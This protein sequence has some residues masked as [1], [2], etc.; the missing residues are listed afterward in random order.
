MKTLFQLFTGLS[1]LLLSNLSLSAQLQ[2]PYIL[3][4]SATQQS[5]NC[6]VLTEDVMNASGTAWNKNKISLNN[7]FDYYFDVNLGCKDQTGADGI[8]FILQTQGTNLGATG[9]GIGFQNIS[10]SL[11]VLIDTWQNA[12]DGDPPFDHVS[13]QMNGDISHLTS[14]NLAGPV[15]ALDG[16]DNIEDCSWHIFRI[17]W[18]VTT[19]LLEVSIDGA[20]RVSVQKD[21]VADIFGGE[22]MVYW[23]FGSATG[24]SA[25]KQ[26]FCAALRPQLRFDNHQLFCE[27][28][29][30]VFGDDS[31]SFGSITRRLWDF[32]DGTTSAD[33]NPPPHLYTKPGKYEV[34]LVIEDNGGCISDTMKQ[35]VT[36]GT[37]PQ[38]DFTID[39]LCTDRSVTVTNK[40]TLGVGTIRQWDW[41]FG[42]GQISAA[43]QPSITYTDTGTYKIK[44]QATSAQGCSTSMQ[45][46]SKVYPTP[47]ISATGENACIGQPISFTG[48]DETPLVPLLQW[49]WDFGNGQQQSGQQLNYIY[50]AGGA[51]Q[52]ALHVAST[53]GCLSDTSYVPVNITDINLF[54]GNDTLAARGE[55]LQLNAR[56]NGSGLQFTWSPT[57]GLTDPGIA[58]P[59]AYLQQDQVY[60]LTVTSSEGCVEIDTL[61]V[62]V[63]AGPDFYVPTAFSPNNDGRNDV[64]R[65]ISPGVSQLDF[66]CVWSRWGQE[67]FRTQSL[68]ATW[69]GNFK[70]TPLP[71]GTYVWM[72]QGTDYKGRLF[73]RR[74]TVTIVR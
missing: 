1:W 52:A 73:S 47:R 46:A 54:A 74:G 23:G 51:Y 17:K 25:N 9:R 29:P 11:G 28:A 48:T 39:Q 42:N 35:D 27:G 15:T 21:L 71:A 14:N 18:D 66:F 10:P 4:G 7:S 53:D 43:Q 70:G 5:C 67:V 3:N 30:I 2:T 34:R 8:A 40:T 72:I 38:T 55:P 16:N 59:V 63:Y 6:Y 44:L 20:L 62:K 50:P 36:I 12:S 68:F 69:D 24:G 65:A 32:G 13:I 57:T 64:F 19:K 49:Y 56:T 33:A 58:D 41:D 37:Y 61:N 26:Q 22:P 60:H 45:K 31:K